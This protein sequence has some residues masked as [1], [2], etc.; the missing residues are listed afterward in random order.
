MRRRRCPSSVE[1]GCASATTL[2]RIH[3]LYVPAGGDEPDPGDQSE[4]PAQAGFS[5]GIAADECRKAKPASRRC[6]AGDLNIAPYES[7]VWS[8]KQLLKVVSHTPEE[9]A[10][11]LTVMEDGLWTDL[12]RRHFP[13][14]VPVF[15]WWSYRSKDWKQSN[16]GRRL[17]HVW[18]STDLADRLSDVEIVSEVK[19]PG[20]PVRSCS[21]HRPLR[22][23][24]LAP[25]RL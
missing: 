2:I 3:N 15:T 10:G 22:A 4:I 24:K 8:H 5:R 25:V 16:R 1:P 21:G 14:E 6:S 23:L 19:E 20:T 18:G 13:M 7:D 11:L 9:C 12:M 17:D